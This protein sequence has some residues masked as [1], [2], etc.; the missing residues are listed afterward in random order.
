MAK[1]SSSFSFPKVLGKVFPKLLGKKS[2]STAL[3]ALLVWAIYQLIANHQAAQPIILPSSTTPVQIYSS[4]GGDNLQ[5][6]YAQTIASAQKSVTFVIYALKDPLVVGALQK[7]SD[8]GI[9]VYIVCDAKASPGV[10]RLLPK[11]KI[12]RRLG[13]GLMH[14]KILIIDNQRILLGSANMTTKSL[15]T[16]GNLVYGI[17]NPALAEALT[18]KAF[19]M[20]EEG[21]STPLLHKETQ[22]AGQNLELWILPDDTKAVDRMITALRSA[23]K[24]M[25]IAMFTFT[26]MDFAQE[27]IDAAKRG[28]Q[29]DIV[30]D[31]YSS[32]G[33]N[34]KVVRTLEQANIPVRLSTGNDLL[35]YKFVE[36]DQT[37]LINGSANWTNNAFKANDDCF[38]ILSPLNA[39]QQQKLDQM[40]KV[41]WS[42]SSLSTAESSKV[43]DPFLPRKRN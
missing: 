21:G 13:E 42:K 14:Q 30:L 9:P 24:T 17:D 25:R 18:A 11:A 2:S 19:S 32:K 16:Y 22:V 28:V 1:R 38:I 4:Q 41:I 31:R 26:R 3:I 40:W 43:K 29:V 34:A 36:I 10:S 5:Q 8:D 35:H 37:T 23:Q 27:I 6:L 15:T 12:V 39:A 7:K 20:D 33:A